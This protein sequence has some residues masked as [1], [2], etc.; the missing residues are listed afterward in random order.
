M[1][2]FTGADGVL[3][4][5]GAM[6]N[7]VIFKRT[8][9]LLTGMDSPYQ[10]NMDVKI[11]TAWEHLTLAVHYKGEQT[12]CREMKKQ[13]CSYTKGEKDSAA[14]RNRIVRAETLEEYKEIFKEYLL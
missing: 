6:V 9:D 5:T 1:L 3:F 12:A 13:L 8:K 7:P 14:L 11:K 10:N 2:K 4:A